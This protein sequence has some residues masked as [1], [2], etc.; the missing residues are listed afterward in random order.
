MAKPESFNK[1]L[2]LAEIASGHEGVNSHL[3]GNHSLRTSLCQSFPGHALPRFE[4]FPSEPFGERK[5]RPPHRQGT[6]LTTDCNTMLFQLDQHRSAMYGYS[7][8]TMPIHGVASLFPLPNESV[9]WMPNPHD[10]HL[11]PVVPMISQHC[12]RRQDEALANAHDSTVTKLGPG[13]HMR[14]STHRCCI[15]RARA[16]RREV[17]SKETFKEALLQME[18]ERIVMLMRTQDSDIGIQGI[19][20][21]E[22]WTL[23]TQM[24][25]C[26]CACLFV[27]VCVCARTSQPSCF[28]SPPSVPSSPC[29][30]LFLPYPFPIYFALGLEVAISLCNLSP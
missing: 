15:E 4:T 21:V 2:V 5:K 25:A 30:F 24:C 18:Q 1:L 16:V 8:S 3:S 9:K 17:P 20:L 6:S 12:G 13:Q 7:D 10:C 26:L 23:H 27:C 22:V 11:Q 29:P 28:L 19:W 14:Q